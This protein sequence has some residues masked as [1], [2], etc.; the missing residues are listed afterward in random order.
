MVDEFLSHTIKKSILINLAKTSKT[1]LFL[2]SVSQ[3]AGLS[4]YNLPTGPPR[5]SAV[6]LSD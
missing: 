2:T 5:R 3:L 1:T 4:G 6:S